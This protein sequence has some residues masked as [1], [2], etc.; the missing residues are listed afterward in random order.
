MIRLMLCKLI[1]HK[2]E[3]LEQDNDRDVICTRCGSHGYWHQD[4]WQ[5]GWFWWPLRLWWT[6]RDWWLLLRQALRA[7]WPR[8]KR[9]IDTRVDD[10]DIPF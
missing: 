9:Q 3:Q 8:P 10:D 5:L 4:E 6:L 1:G 2:V 7:A